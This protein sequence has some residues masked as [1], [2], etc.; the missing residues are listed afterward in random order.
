M[1]EKQMCPASNREGILPWVWLYVG[2]PFYAECTHFHQQFRSKRTLWQD[3]KKETRYRPRLVL[4]ILCLLLVGCSPPS[5]VQESPLICDIKMGKIDTVAGRGIGDG[6]SAVSAALVE[7]MGLAFDQSGNLFIADRLNLRIRRVDAMTG[8]ITTVAGDGGSTSPYDVDGNLATSDS[9]NYPSDIVFDSQGDLIYVEG[10]GV[11]RLDLS[12]GLL[13][14]VA[15]IVAPR[16]L[17]IDNGDNLFVACG[18][19]RTDSHKVQRIDAATGSITVIAGTE[20]SGYSGDGGPATSAQ[21]NYPSDVALDNFNRIYIADTS[22]HRIRKVDGMGNI[23]TIAGIGTPGYSG[24]GGPATSAELYYPTRLA[25]YDGYLY[26]SDGLNSK[27]RK[28]GLQNGIISTVHNAQGRTLGIAFDNNDDLHYGVKI[29][30]GGRVNKISEQGIVTAIAGNGSLCGWT[31]PGLATSANFDFP[32]GITLDDDGNLFI[33]TISEILKIDATSGLIQTI[34]RSAPVIN[35][36]KIELDENGNILIITTAPSKLLRLNPQTG[37]ITTIAGTNETG[38]SGDGG[39]ATSAQFDYPEA[40]TIDSA[41]NIFIADTGNDRIRRID[42]TTGIITTVAGTGEA[43]FGGDNGPATSAQLYIPRDVIVDNSDNLYIADFANDRIRRVDATTG[44]IT[45]YAGSGVRGYSGDDGPAVSADLD[46]PIGLAMDDEENLF[47]AQGLFTKEH[48]IRRVDA[49]T[50]IITTVAGSGHT[51]FS[52]DGGPA[53]I[54]R[55]S[56]PG[57]IALDSGGNLYLIDR[58][59]YVI[60]AV[61]SPGSTFLSPTEA[62]AGLAHDGN[63]LYVSE[64]IGSRRIYKVDPAS[65]K[66]VSSFF[67]PTGSNPNG[68]AYDSGVA[69]LFVTDIGGFGAGKVYEIDTVGTV[70][71]SF[72][73]PFR[74]GSVAFDGSNLYISDLDTRTILVTDRTGNTIRSFDS[75]LRPAGMAY[76]SSTGHLW[77]VD[78]FNNKISEIT[79]DGVLI[80]SFEG[81]RKSGIQGIGAVTIRGSKLYIAEVSD[82]DPFNPPDIPGVIYTIGLETNPPSTSATVTPLPNENGWNNNPIVV[83]LSACDD[84]GSP[85]IKEIHYSVNGGPETIVDEHIAQVPIESEGTTTLNY[86]A[87]DDQGNVESAGTLVVRIDLTVPSVTFNG[88]CPETVKLGDMAFIDVSVT[89]NLSGIASQSV[90][91]GS[92]ALDST[93]AGERTFSVTAQDIADNVTSNTCSY[94]VIYDF[95]GAGGFGPPL[96]SPPAV[97]SANAGAVVPVKWQLPDGSGGY[98]SDLSVMDSILCQEIDCGDYGSVIGNPVPAESSGGSGLRYDTAANQYIFNW[99]TDSSMAGRCYVLILRLNDGSEYRANFAMS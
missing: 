71:N 5:L 39:P 1:M 60:R 27:I 56:F 15:R 65:G 72:P 35:N 78:I 62:P 20:M 89:D 49:E 55:L 43:G 64:V 98:I 38:F 95:T 61:R 23:T 80:R 26:I 10:Y 6:G 54:A 11:R 73:I 4:F 86:F 37:M 51:G 32:T 28:V 34:S 79:T 92:H 17:E 16:G 63:F 52:G 47:I 75:H 68:L 30:C 8:I 45:T 81:P 44:I 93:T 69:H 24:D 90:S 76:D 94:R 48:R 67:A 97:N 41:G 50:G 88:T 58:C 59:N 31:N 2:W 3:V 13:S 66:I 22:N 14:N 9:L 53:L 46:R 70:V 7:P 18:A 99:G 83:Q 33:A 42:A 77:V 21:L 36:R 91:N 96:V 84:D 19:W 40:V 57:K 29:S 85:C 12:S 87:I 25:F 74:G 82:P